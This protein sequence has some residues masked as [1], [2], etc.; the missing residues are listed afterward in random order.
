MELATVRVETE[1]VLSPTVTPASVSHRDCGKLQRGGLSTCYW[2]DPG[3][4]A[5]VCSGTPDGLMTRNDKMLT[6]TDTARGKKS[7]IQSA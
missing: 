3:G 5:L 7:G 2:P 1:A 4:T 6:P